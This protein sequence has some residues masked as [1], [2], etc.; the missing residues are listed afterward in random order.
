MLEGNEVSGSETFLKD[1]RKYWQYYP[2]QIGLSFGFPPGLNKRYFI[3]LKAAKSQGS[4]EFKNL[5]QKYLQPE[6][7]ENTYSSIIKKDSPI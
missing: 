4:Q 6:Y 2:S 5:N 3:N 7:M 1:T